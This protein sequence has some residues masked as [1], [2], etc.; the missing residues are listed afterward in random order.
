MDRLKYFGIWIIIVIAFF[1]YSDVLIYL[2]LNSNEVGGKVYNMTHKE[3]VEQ[4]EEEKL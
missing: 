4:L 2:S 1:I 3:V